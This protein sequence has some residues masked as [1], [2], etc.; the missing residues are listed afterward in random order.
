MTGLGVGRFLVGNH[1]RAFPQPRELDMIGLRVGRFLV[2]AHRGY[3]HQPG[4]LLVTTAVKVGTFI[5]NNHRRAFPNRES[6]S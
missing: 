3:C 4:E 1:R 6:C 5:V 2:D